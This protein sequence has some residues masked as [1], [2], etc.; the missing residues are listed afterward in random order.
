MKN[1]KNNRLYSIL[2][3]VCVAF[4]LWL[5]VVNNVSQEDSTTFYNIPVVMGGESILSDQNLM[6]TNM[7]T[8]TV[9]LR[10]SGARSDLNKLDASNLSV[11]VDLSKINEPGE[12]IALSYTP[13][14]P[15]GVSNDDIVVEERNPSVIY[16][17]VDYRRNR[18]IPV[19]VKYTGTRS[20]DHLYDT[21]NVVLDYT[22]VT[23]TGPASVVDQ[24]QVA[25]IEVDLTDRV[26]SFSESLRYTLCDE[27][28]EPVDA[29]QITTNV[30]QIRVDMQIQ[31]IQ[32]LELVADVIYGGGATEENTS[33][34]IEPAT[35][36]VSGS[37]AL[38]AE[39]GETYTIGTINLAELERMSNE[40]TYSITLPDGI[41]NQTGV[42]EATVTVRFTG[43]KIREFTIANIACINVPDGLEAEIITT[44]LTIQ[45]RGPFGEIDALTEEDITAAVDFTGA[46]VG[47][48]T[49]RVNITFS[50]E[51]A[52]VGAMRTS[53]V[54]ATVQTAGE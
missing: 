9:S 18:E 22:S 32:E 42:S 12:R 10:L 7:S 45:V 6:I 11:R 43:L 53:S 5:Y 29:A 1:Q 52:N 26:E 48:A 24:I 3:S 31:R 46:E 37:D 21:E 27:N 47:T 41:V 14:Y 40:L 35:I 38:L 30:E 4:G 17:D 39:L 20:E 8:E 34:K 16:V 49:Y 25:V 51:F 33:V 2:L 13:S 44:S 23:V 36:R 15:S 28:E 54:T 19:Q 50:E